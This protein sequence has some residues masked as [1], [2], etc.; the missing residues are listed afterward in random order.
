MVF[1]ALLMTTLLGLA[2]LV[3]D[4]GMMLSWRR[5]AQSAA[6]AAAL[7]AI[8]DVF[9]GRLREDAVLTAIDY[10]HVRHQLPGATVEV[11]C[12]PTMGDYST[13]MVGDDLYLEVIVTLDIDTFLIQILDGIDNKQKVVA[14]AVAGM[15]PR[16]SGVGAIALDPRAIPGL[17]VDGGA[18]LS[19]DNAVIINSRG[20]GYGAHGEYIDY[21]YKT[22]AATASNNSFFEAGYIQVHGGVDDP[23]NYRNI[24]PLKSSPLFTG[25]S[26]SPDPLASLP[27][28]GTIPGDGADFT[29]WGV[30]SAGNGDVEILQPGIYENITINNGADVTFL[31]GIYILSPT[32]PNQGLAING[33]PTIVAE[34]V[35]FYVT[36]SNYMVDGYAPGFNDLWDGALELN[37]NTGSLPATGPNEGS[38]VDFAT[39][40]INIGGGNVSFTPYDDP[41]NPNH[42]F[43][44]ILFYQ[45]RRSESAISLESTPEDNTRIDGLIYAKWG[46][47]NLAGGGRYDGQFVVGSISI[48]GHSSISISGAGDKTGFAY[49]VFLIE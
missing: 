4:G 41:I 12:P 35:M 14:R 44:G 29:L 34:G 39:V 7:A 32:L 42:P 15:E 36:G 2:G 27:I 1:C 48:A 47:L 46:S 25:A 19:V 31:P 40:K 3:L 45:R 26:I 5:R 22:Y 23:V 8:I 13:D 38:N 24:D 16:G 49:K 10:V 9:Q 17:A 21:G 43:N 30:V 11:N 28:P 6:D 33:D 18:S 37:P 20:S